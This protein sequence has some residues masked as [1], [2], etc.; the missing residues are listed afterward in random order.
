M[1][2]GLKYKKDFI[3]VCG[4]LYQVLKTNY[5]QDYIIKFTKLETVIYFNKNNK[6]KEKNDGQIIQN[7][8]EKKEEKKANDEDKNKAKEKNEENKEENKENAMDNK[9]GNEEKEEDKKEAKR[10]Y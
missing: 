9:E 6:N 10:S 4:Q 3:V 5:N 8:E 7:N 1:K 2:K